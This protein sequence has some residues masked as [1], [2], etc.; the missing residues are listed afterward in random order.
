MVVIS[1]TQGCVKEPSAVMFLTLK[2][3]D[4]KSLLLRNHRLAC[5]GLGF[6]VTE[7]YATQP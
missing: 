2:H 7:H 1:V 4:V 3:L 6:E 5:F